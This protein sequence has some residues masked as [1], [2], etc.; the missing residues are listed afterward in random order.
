MRH[1]DNT[2]IFCAQD[3][4]LGCGFKSKTSEIYSSVWRTNTSLDFEQNQISE[5]QSLI[6]CTHLVPEVVSG[7]AVSWFAVGVPSSR[8][9]FPV[10]GDRTVVRLGGALVPQGPDPRGGP[11]SWRDQPGEAWSAAQVSPFLDSCPAGV[12]CTGG[13]KDGDCNPVV[14]R[15]VQKLET[16]LLGSP[17]Y[18]NSP[19]IGLLE[20]AHHC[21]PFVLRIRTHCGRHPDDSILGRP[22]VTR[23]RISACLCC[24]RS[25]RH[26]SSVWTY[27]FINFAECPKVQTR[28][29]N[30]TNQVAGIRPQSQWCFQLL[31]NKKEEEKSIGIINKYSLNDH[32]L[33]A[34]GY[35]SSK[36]AFLT[37]PAVYTWA[38]CP[39]LAVL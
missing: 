35:K 16:L 29:S 9:R 2:C 37:A 12:C 20:G 31:W 36:R 6:E 5:V 18:G 3:W 26:Q 8:G 28:D 15:E 21:T 13:C 34:P 38:H 22:G 30:L 32:Q 27:L 11:S 19:C 1:K 17:A 39:I 7:D 25:I 4:N 10:R 24:Q 23:N 33:W 14:R